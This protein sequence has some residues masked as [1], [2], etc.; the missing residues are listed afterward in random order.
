MNIKKTL[1]NRFRGWLP[2]TPNL[3]NSSSTPTFKKTGAMDEKVLT[4]QNFA[5]TPSNKLLSGI[6]IGGSMVALLVGLLLWSSLNS[7]YWSQRNTLIMSG[8]TKSEIYYFV[9]PLAFDIY[10]CVTAVV[11][12]SYVLILASVYQLNPIIR[13]LI[14]Q[15]N[16]SFALA[17]GFVVGGAIGVADSVS[18]AVLYSYPIASA[19][20]P[21]HRIFSIEFGTAGI[22][23]VS[24]GTL[25]IAYL[26]LKFRKSLTKVQGDPH[27]FP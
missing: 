10:F 25:W 22:I 19:S 2:K 14:K 4:N 20:D 18:N 23:L 27:D 26:C 11:Y 1:Q 3:P 7:M 9:D 17:G 16:I 15:K 21:F 8:W 12:S 24:L 6:I 13:T 5:A